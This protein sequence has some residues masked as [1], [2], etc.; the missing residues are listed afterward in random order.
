MKRAG[1]YLLIAATLTFVGS[2]LIYALRPI[3]G[4]TSVNLVRP[5]LSLLEVAPPMLLT[6]LIL[7]PRTL[8]LAGLMVM[9]MVALGWH[10]ML[11]LQDVNRLRFAEAAPHSNI[12]SHRHPHTSG[13]P[14]PGEMLKWHR[15]DVSL[16]EHALL[17]GGL[18]AGAVCPW[19][20]AVRPG[21]A[22]LAALLM[23]AGVLGAALRGVRN[24]FD[25]RK[26]W[27]LGFAG[28]WATLVAF[29]LF[30]TVVNTRLSVPLAMAGAVGLGLAACATVNAQLRLGRNIS[31]S[32]AVILGMI[33][34]AAATF[35]GNAALAACAVLAIA[36]IVVALIQ[37]TT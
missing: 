30:S 21:W 29:A 13:P 18:L 33:G 14:T 24:G 1:T 6:D 37:V 16:S 34:I 7:R 15:H 3:V 27:A 22:M 35:A 32:V 11:R 5:S 36:I 9:T 2:V 8:A 31:Y 23:L 25:V 20:I 28:G 4:G 19:L 12:A 17:I 10:A 26:S